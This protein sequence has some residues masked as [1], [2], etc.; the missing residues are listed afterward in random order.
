PASARS[1]SLLTTGGFSPYHWP[2]GS[3][4]DGGPKVPW[5]NATPPLD[6]GVCVAGDS[7]SVLL[8]ELRRGQPGHGNAFA[9]AFYCLRLGAPHFVSGLDDRALLVHR[10]LLCRLSVPL[11][12]AH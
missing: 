12:H 11:P 10:P 1:T 2:K 3:A 9:R 4:I 7:R 8:P 5:D 6:A